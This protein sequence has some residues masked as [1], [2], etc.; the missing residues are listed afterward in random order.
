MP[1]ARSGAF[2]AGEAAR[3]GR[4]VLALTSSQWDITDPGRG[5]RFVAAATWWSTARPTPKVD[6]AE[7]DRDRAH[8]VNATGAENVAQA[9]ARVGARLIHISTDYVFSGGSTAAP[10]PTRSTTTPGR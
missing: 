7:A 8:A 9:C 4:D 6:A 3:R 1:V 5:E 2:L 10:R